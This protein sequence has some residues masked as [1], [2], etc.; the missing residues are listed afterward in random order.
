MANPNL[1]FSGIV[2][3]N[4]KEC[5]PQQVFITSNNTDAIYP[6][7]P[8]IAQADGSYL[9]TRAGASTTAAT[10]GIS[11]MCTE[12]IQYKDAAG[13]YMRRNARYLPAATL[14]TNDFER[15][16]VQAIFPREGML[17]KAK[18]SAAVA[19]IA[20]ARALIH[21]NVYHVYGTADPASGVSGIAVDPAS[22]ATTAKQWRVVDVLDI[23]Q[24]DP[25][26]VSFT[27]IVTP[28]LIYAAPLMGES[29]TGI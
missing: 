23:A 28:N 26:Q 5:V 10:D 6:G 14:W 4:A 3:L 13:G 1:L 24:N 12:I 18:A 17:F 16:Q 20:A 9:R 25:T 21:S 7:E 19:S 2:P 15:S 22:I 29:S 27:L 11:A 8:L